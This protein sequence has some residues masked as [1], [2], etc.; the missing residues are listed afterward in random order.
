MNSGR[1]A[2]VILAAGLS[3]RM[4][5]FKPLLLLGNATVTDHVTG[6]FIKSGIA[7][8]LVT[9]YRGEELKAGIKKHEITIINNPDYEKGMLSS[10]QAGV[11]QMPP[12]YQAFFVLPVDIPLV[13]PETI[14]QLMDTGDEN[15]GK[16]IYPVYNGERGHPPLIPSRLIPEILAW[17]KDGGLKAILDLHADLA[18]DLPVKD[19]FI[20]FDIDTREDY[21]ELLK[22]YR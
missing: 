11:R 9:G 13:K 15:P 16:I 4:K 7:V 22:Q 18:E 6:T 14:K 12:G 10:V 2:A 17:N 20:L 1:F 21:K 19:K 5:E 3:T 8:Y